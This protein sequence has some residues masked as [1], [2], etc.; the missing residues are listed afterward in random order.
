MAGTVKSRSVVQTRTHAQKFF[1]KLHKRYG[2]D[3]RREEESRCVSLS[4]HVCVSVCGGVKRRLTRSTALQTTCVLTTDC[5]CRMAGGASLEEALDA[6]AEDD[7]DL[8]VRKRSV[9]CSRA[10]SVGSFPCPLDDAAKREC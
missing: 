7:S 9:R 1:Q 10:V 5:T 6:T 3:R 2:V 4:V 8:E